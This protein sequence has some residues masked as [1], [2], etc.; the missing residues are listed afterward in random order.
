[1]S[2]PADVV[3][4]DRAR[5]EGRDLDGLRAL[6]A[7]DVV[8]EWTAT[9]ERFTGPENVVGVNREYPEGWSIHVRAVVAQGDV[10][11]SDVEV[12]MAGVGVFRVAAFMRVAAGKVAS[13][14][15][16]WIGVGA[17][18]PPAWRARFATPADAS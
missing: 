2:E 10:V 4:A 13:S 18:E 12:P 3:R 14:V 11:V 9:G 17:D 7:P 5:L 8:V 1:M 16:Y 15:E 6:L